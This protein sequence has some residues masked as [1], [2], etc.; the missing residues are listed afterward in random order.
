MFD[1]WMKIFL[2][3]SARANLDKLIHHSLLVGI[4]AS[5][6]KLKR[7]AHNN[8]DNR[9]RLLKDYLIKTYTSII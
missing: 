2:A 3:G 9:E 1:E 5:G 8:I 6:A 7:F 4:K